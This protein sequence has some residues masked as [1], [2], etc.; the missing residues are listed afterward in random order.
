MGTSKLSGKPDEMLGATSDGLVS[1]PGGVQGVAILLVA[2]CCGNMEKLWLCGPLGSCARIIYLFYKRICS[3]DS[4]LFTN[5]FIYVSF[6]CGRKPT[7]NI[8]FTN[9]NGYART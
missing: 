6:L 2:S 1:H 4:Y 5:V 9:G 8:R 7:K 3:R